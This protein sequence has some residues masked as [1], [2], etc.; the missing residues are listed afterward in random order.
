MFW[1]KTM[2]CV[3]A[4]RRLTRFQSC[5]VAQVIVVRGVAPWLGAGG[6]SASNETASSA[7]PTISANR[8]QECVSREK[9]PLLARA[10]PLPRVVSPY[11]ANLARGK[12]IAANWPEQW[13]L[14][15]RADIL[16][17]RPP[18]AHAAPLR[19]LRLAPRVP[20]AEVRQSKVAG[21]RRPK[22][23]RP[24]CAMLLFAR[25]ESAAL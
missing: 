14:A 13:P 23:S 1:T 12:A 5:G 15:P 9:G 19:H 3:G 20:V 7:A 21:R 6:R 4:T 22:A 8:G 11:R 18:S 24:V 2:H 17:T 25:S 10:Q 16:T